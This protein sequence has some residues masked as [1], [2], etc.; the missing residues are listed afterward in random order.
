LNKKAVELA[1]KCEQAKVPSL[2]HLRMADYNLVYE[3]SDDTF[4]MLDAL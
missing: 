3:P 1:K 2:D 4:L